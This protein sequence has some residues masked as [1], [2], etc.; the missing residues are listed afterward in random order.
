MDKRRHVAVWLRMLA[1]KE[2]ATARL[3]NNLLKAQGTK[4]TRAFKEGGQLAA[5]K[6]IKQTEAEWVRLFVATYS[7]TISDFR[8]YLHEQ[9]GVIKSKSRFTE[10][11]KQWVATQAYLKST[12]VTQTNHEIVK[13]VITAGVEN[14]SSEVE[15]AKNIKDHFKSQ[16]AIGRARTIARTEVHNAAS[17]GMQNA[18]EESQLNL[19]REWVSVIDDRTRED[20]ADADGQVRGMDEPFDIGGEAVDFP[21][22][23]SPENSINCRCTLVY[24]PANTN[25]AGTGDALGDFQE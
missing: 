6:A 14:G 13:R 17:F 21:G 18:A 22:D 7:R 1:T 23:G 8:E 12:Y 10:Y 9:L 15:I 3:A 25:F 24:N 2:I 20:H 5:F 11:A 19:T 16:A 4:I